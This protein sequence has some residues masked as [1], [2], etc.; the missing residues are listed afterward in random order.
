MIQQNVNIENIGPIEQLDIKCPPDGGVVVLRGRNGLGKSTALSSAQALVSGNG[1][2]STRDDAPSAG[3]VNGFGAMIHVGAKTTRAGEVEVS[4]IEGKLNIA[5]LVKP[6]LKDPVA[7]DRQRIKALISIT[8]VEPTAKAFADVIGNEMADYV[9]AATWAGKD[10]LD[11]ASKAKRDLEQAARGKEDEA[12]LREGQAKAHE[13]A[14]SGV[15]MSG[16]CDEQKLRNASTIASGNL[17]VLQERQEAS[18]RS[19]N[20]LAEAREKLDQVKANYTGPTVDQAI[21][22]VKSSENNLASATATVNNLE[23]QLAEAKSAQERIDLKL[24]SARSSL[25]AA[26]EYTEAVAMY[27][28][29]LE[30]TATK[31]PSP[32]ELEAAQQAMDDASNALEQGALIRNAMAKLREAKDARDQA[33]K[34]AVTA[35]RLRDSA[36]L[37]DNVLSN[38]IENDQLFVRDGRL[39]TNHHAR[40]ETLFGDLSEGERWTKAFDVAAPIVGEHGILILP[41]NFWEGLDPHNRA[42]VAD[43]ARHHK[44]VVLTAEATDGE[45]RAEQFEGIHSN[46]H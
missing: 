33:N 32:D 12:N 11:V 6:P 5:D 23:R 16:E 27:E 10:M 9:S 43:L 35:S 8:G 20:Q 22:D 40:G 38:A 36:K 13:E 2:L 4:S 31:A 30:G 1:K 7:A 25:R 14:A 34:A 44:I 28:A 42:H 45:L 26:E 39:C 37:I 41:Q 15:D 46:A 18:E 19:A 29:V 24:Q 21:A 3:R 17:R